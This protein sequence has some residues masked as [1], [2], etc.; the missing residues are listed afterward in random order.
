MTWPV[1]LTTVQHYRADCDVAGAS[2]PFC[3]V[4]VGDERKFVTQVKKK[5]LA[6]IWDERVT[7]ELPKDDETLEIVS[8]LCF[9]LEIKV[10]SCGSRAVS[11]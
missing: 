4:Y 6:P 2:D 3:Q 8:F 10:A 11:K 1:A 5:T 9:P 7:L